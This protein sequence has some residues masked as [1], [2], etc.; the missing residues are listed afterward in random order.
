MPFYRS[1]LVALVGLAVPAGSLPAQAAGFDCKGRVLTQ[2]Q[3]TVC[4]DQE[5]NQ[6]DERVARR[7]RDMQKR[8]GLGLYL[9]MRYW[10]NRNQEARDQCERDRACLIAGYRQQQRVLERLQTCLDSSIRKRSC[11]RVVISNEET[12]SQGA[13]AGGRPRSQ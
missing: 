2:A 1:M 7:I 11:L 9:G 6:A 13:T 12:A 4:G 8:Y 10:A 3:I 5:L